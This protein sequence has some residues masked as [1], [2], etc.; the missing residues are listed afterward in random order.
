MKVWVL[1]HRDNLVDNSKVDSVYA[2]AESAF[3]EAKKRNS[4][5]C[6]DVYYWVYE[7]DLLP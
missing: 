7:L 3:N 2:T 5:G 1:M 4:D 6:G